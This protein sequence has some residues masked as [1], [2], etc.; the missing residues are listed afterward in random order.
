MRSETFI[1]VS[2]FITLILLGSLFLL[3]PFS[4]KGPEALTYIDTLF[5]ATSAVCVTGL[6]TVDTALYSRFGQIVILILMQMGG[7]GLISFSTL[8]IVLPS[9]KIS[10]KGSTII[11]QYFIDSIE[12]DPKKIIELIVFFTLTIET[13]GAIILYYG[14]SPTIKE[15]TLFYALFHSISAFCNA[16][17]SLFSNNL[18]N[19]ARNELVSITIMVLIIMGGI[20]FI[21]IRDIINRCAG[22]KRHLALHTKI[23]IAGTL[24]LILIGGISIFFIEYNHSLKDYILKDKILISL[25]QSVTPRTAGFNT[26]KINNMQLF[27]KLLLL[28]FM[29]IGGSSGSISGG[30]KVTTFF[31][32][33]LI[34]FRKINPQRGVSIFKRR[35]PAATIYRVSFFVIKTMI[36]LF[37]SFIL[38]TI[39]ESLFNP[40]SEQHILTY[41]FECTSAFGTVGLSLG[42]TSALTIAG[43]IIIIGTMFLGRVGL[44]L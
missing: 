2:F 25:F 16:G 6:I 26:I 28:P 30:I 11:K 3:L 36:V 35:I 12:F 18:E 24:L 34:L 10:L 33:I 29:I 4:W 15:D 5:T 32:L 39:S 37:V 22:K 1:L 40:N 19:Y 14:F 31:I 43:K 23:V 38:L 9:R 13:I 41:F 7:L 20:G 17:F 8:Y 42:I 44:I 27:S 21:V